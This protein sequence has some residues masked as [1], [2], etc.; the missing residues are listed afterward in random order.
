MTGEIRP[1]RSQS[2]NAFSDSSAARSAL[3]YC[4]F[5]FLSEREMTLVAGCRLL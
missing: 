2:Y 1:L 5:E 4:R 3:I